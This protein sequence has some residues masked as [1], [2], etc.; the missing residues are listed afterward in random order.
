MLASEQHASAASLVDEAS[1]LS[2]MFAQPLLHSNPSSHINHST[3][4]G[5]N[6]PSTYSNVSNNTAQC[7]GDISNV[8]VGYANETYPT[9]T[10]RLIEIYPGVRD[11]YSTYSHETG[12]HTAVRIPAMPTMWSCVKNAFTR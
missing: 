10:S 9:D 11:A 2:A 4:T 7:N 6:V 1:I 8:D 12:C 3:S 5:S